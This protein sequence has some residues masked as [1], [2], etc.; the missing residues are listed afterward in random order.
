MPILYLSRYIIRNKQAYYYKLQAV[1]D[2]N[3]WE[4]WILFMLDGIEQIAQETILLIDKIKELMQLYKHQIRDQYKFYS[5]DLLNNL[6]KHPY[7]KIEF[8]Q[9]DLN[10]NRLTA[11]RY[12]NAL[13]EDGFL[14]KYKIGTSN[15][16]INHALFDL[17]A[18]KNN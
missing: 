14:L 7:T 15:F 4:S 9:Q 8:I 16:Y 11:S 12:L 2:N 10:V 18:K 13:A 3:D 5:Q 6:F 17:L 1:R